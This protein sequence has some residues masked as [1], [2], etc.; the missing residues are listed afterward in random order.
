VPIELRQP[1]T[2]F[3]HEV[4]VATDAAANEIAVTADILS[5]RTQRD[6][7]AAFQRRLEHRAQHRIVDHD[8]GSIPLGLRQLVGDS[9]AGGEINKTVGRIG[10]RLDE[11]Q[12]HP[13]CRARGLSC[14]S[15]LGDIDAVCKAEGSDPKR[16]HLLLE[17]RFGAAIERSAVQYGVACAEKGE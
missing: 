11:D 15:H 7:R 16:T 10:G 14:L 8:R 6:V 3:L 2:C 9:R 17:Q 12:T 4:G 1:I 5:Q 13:A